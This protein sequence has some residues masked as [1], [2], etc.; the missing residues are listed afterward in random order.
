MT[1]KRQKESREDYLD[2]RRKTREQLRKEVVNVFLSEK[3]GWF[4]GDIQH[5][6]HYKYFVEKLVDGRR[7]Y[8]LRPTFLNKGID[9]QV[10]IEKYDGIVDRRPSHKD[11]LADLRTKKQEN[12][13]EVRK[14]GAAILQVYD[15]EEP[16]VIIKR[17]ALQFMKGFSVELLLKA[18]KWLFIEQDVTYWNYDGRAMLRNALMKEVGED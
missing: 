5:V 10:W 13:T 12:P 8:L 1:I 16:D 18:L 14:L 2:L 4:E 11:L 15:C 7:I 3:K 17:M 6:T 9:F